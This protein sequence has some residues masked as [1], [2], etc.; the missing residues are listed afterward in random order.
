MSR[1]AL[2]LLSAGLDSS[3]NL[4]EAKAAGWEISLC[5][6]FDYGQRAAPREIEAASKLARWAGAPHRVLSL[7]FI[8]EFGG[9]ALIDQKVHLPLGQDVAIDDFKVSTDTAKSVWVPN[10]NGIFLNIAAGFA[11]SLGAEAVIP[12]F[13]A[14]EATTFPDNSTAF[15]S[16]LE[17]SFSYS[18]ANQVKVMCFTDQLDK[19]ALAKRARELNLPIELLWPCYQDGPRWCGQCESCQ[20]DRRALQAAGYPVQD[21]FGGQG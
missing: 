8:A 18:T 14:E 2:L 20:R 7:P 1:K 12:G 11:E 5:L 17:K 13:N 3:V 16:A 15:M 4:A 21:L 19:P 10:R 9:S 6:T